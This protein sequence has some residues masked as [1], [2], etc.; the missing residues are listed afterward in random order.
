[1]TRVL[2]ARARRDRRNG[3][4]ISISIADS[5]ESVERNEFLTILSAY[6]PLLRGI[7]LHNE[8]TTNQR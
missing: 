3:D 7:L 1:M 4:A 6:P 8:S 5:G 2:R